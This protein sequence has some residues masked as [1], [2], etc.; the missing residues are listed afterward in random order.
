MKSF[1]ETKSEIQAEELTGKQKAGG[2]LFLI[3]VSMLI[4]MCFIYVTD[5][6]DTE[7]TKEDLIPTQSEPGYSVWQV[8][9]Y[10]KNNLN[11]PDSYESVSWGTLQPS[12]SEFLI[13]HKYR[14]KNGFG[15]TILQ[16]QVF[17]LDS[18]GNVIRV[19]DM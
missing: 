8:S 3:V 14:A 6:V 1:N 15:A 2:C 13:P 9:Y 11:D 12:G 17:V 10:L 18:T 5:N 4:S 16:S 19:G 7:L